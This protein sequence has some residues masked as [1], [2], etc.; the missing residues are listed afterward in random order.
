M[1][2]KN[3]VEKFIQN[4]VELEVPTPKV[5]IIDESMVTV[6]TTK[7]YWE[8]PYNTSY[9]YTNIVVN[10]NA[11]IQWEEWAIYVFLI[12][13]TMVVA[14]A[15][16]NIRIKIWSNGTY[17]PLMS[18]WN[19]ILAWSSY[20]TKSRMDLYVYKTIH[21]SWWALHLNN[22]TSYSAMSVAEW[23]TGTATS[24]RTMRADYLKQIIEYHAWN[25]H[26]ST[27]Q[28]KLTTQTAYTSKGSATKV[29]QITTN[30]L[31]Q[32]TWIT[33]VTIQHQDISW[34]AD[35]A[36]VLELDNTASYTPSGDY[37]PATKKY[38]DDAVSQSWGGASEDYVKGMDYATLGDYNSMFQIQSDLYKVLNAL[39]DEDSLWLSAWAKWTDI[40]GTQASMNLVS[41]SY[42]CM[43]AVA[44]SEYALNKVIANSTALNE[45]LSSW[46]SMSVIASSELAMSIFASSSSIMSSII[47]NSVALDA[48]SESPVA[49]SEILKNTSLSSSLFTTLFG[50][51][52]FANTVYNNNDLLS[53][54]SKNTNA[55]V[56]LK[57][58]SVWSSILLDLEKMNIIMENAWSWVIANETSANLRGDTPL[59]SI[60]QNNL[61]DTYVAKDEE[62]GNSVIVF[63]IDSSAAT[64]FNISRYSQNG[65]TSTWMY[66]VDGWEW[67]TSSVALSATPLS[68]ALWST[69]QHT[70]VIKPQTYAYGWAKQMWNRNTTNYWNST[71]L[72]FSVRNLPIFAL[73]S[74]ST[75][76]ANYW[77]YYMF[78]QC[79][80]LTKVKFSA[81]S[82]LTS[83]WWY[84]MYYAFYNCTA[85]QSVEWSF[86]KSNLTTIW[87]Y[88]MSYAFYN[89]T[90]L[91]KMNSWLTLASITSMGSYFM[92]FTWQACAKLSGL[93]SWF[94]LP[95]TYSTTGYCQ[96]MCYGC[97]AMNSNSP[98]ENLTFKYTASNCFYGTQIS[99]TSPTTNSNIAVHRT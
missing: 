97:T 99:T 82:T 19:A 54:C 21:Q 65:A 22:D 34:K 49:I 56:G 60:I 3:I 67:T 28:D 66:S 9:Y 41:H 89:C 5:Y 38:V 69:G 86:I 33:E 50:N 93:P 75:G 85:L 98:A 42:A 73:M 92:Y 39:D 11:W 91:T 71:W 59:R 47:S 83:A 30:T 84:F 48:I 15:Y 51:T 90:N 1:T 74:T 45:L 26:D 8:A 37:H 35:K 2:N 62:A 80:T 6:S 46:I 14:S 29:P 12:D 55:M 57:A 32:V 64:S 52:V 87:N 70:I 81:T 16:R 43:V 25:L 61:I 23:Q 96:W 77:L 76:F 95:N 88:F 53:L 17:I 31:G 79:T 94:Q 44:S 63:D 24:A 36:N 72:T 58:S 10:E 40:V 20:F 13:T 68:V 4:G 18:A 78:A 7:T 27:K